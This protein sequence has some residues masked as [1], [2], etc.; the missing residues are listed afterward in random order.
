MRTVA[1]PSLQQTA[2]AQLPASAARRY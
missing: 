2:R 1:N